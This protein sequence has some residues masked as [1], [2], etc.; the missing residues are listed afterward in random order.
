MLTLQRN[1][2]QALAA[3]MLAVGGIVFTKLP[4]IVILFSL[5]RLNTASAKI[6]NARTK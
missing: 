6:R 2:P 3:A 1:R 5:A 4:L